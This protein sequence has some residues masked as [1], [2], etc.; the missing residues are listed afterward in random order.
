MTLI[1]SVR[2]DDF[3]VMAADGMGYTYPEAGVAVPYEA[4]KLHAANGSWI[5]GFAGWAGIEVQHQEL[6]SQIEKRVMDFGSDVRTGGPPYLEALRTL[7]KKTGGTSKQSTVRLAGFDSDGN[8]HVYEVV[9]PDGQPYF[10]A[11]A[12]A[13]A[14]GSSA[15]TAR[16]YRRP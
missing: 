5:I 6:E 16:R 12:S 9:F 7:L 13:C 10:P 3:I 2:T 15:R 1:I 14:A 11:N 8:P 4:Q